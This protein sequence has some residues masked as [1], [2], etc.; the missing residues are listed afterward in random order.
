MAPFDVFL[1]AMSEAGH[2]PSSVAAHENGDRSA[3]WAPDSRPLFGVIRKAQVLTG[4]SV[5]IGLEWGSDLV[6]FVWVAES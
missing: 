3:V 5:E 6:A 4:V 1:A 2:P